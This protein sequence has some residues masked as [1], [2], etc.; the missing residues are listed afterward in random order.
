[1]SEQNAQVPPSDAPSGARPEFTLRAILVGVVVAAFV[2]AAFPYVVLKLG[3][4]PNISVVAAFLG[5]MF[6]GLIGMVVGRRG[7]RYEYNIVQTAGTSAGQQGFMVIVLAA[8]DLLAAKSDN[9]FGLHLKTMQIFVWLSLSG[10][11]GVL[12]AVPLRKHYID[13][14]QLTFADGV[15]AG[16]TLM[17]LDQAGSAAKKG[18]FALIVGG[19]LSAVHSWLRDGQVLIT[20]GLARF[21][22]ENTAFGANGGLLH[23]G[24]NWSLL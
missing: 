13:E 10:G 2:G 9:Q 7:N 6:V 16:E 23:V 20:K 11:L 5:Y 18:L 24:V 21:V 22:P 12:L 3:F 4:G 15:A 14:E 19:V 1:M 17:V 8:F